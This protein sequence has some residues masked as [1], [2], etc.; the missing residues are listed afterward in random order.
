VTLAPSVVT[1]NFGTM[2][3]APFPSSGL[4]VNNLDVSAFQAG[5]D[6][7]TANNGT[8]QFYTNSAS[9]TPAFSGGYNVGITA[10]NVSFNPMTSAYYQFTITPDPG[11]EVTLTDLS[12]GT[13]STSTGP[14]DLGI[15]TSAD[16]FS[17]DI[18]T[19]TVSTTGT[20]QLREPSFTAIT[21]S[22]PLTVRIYGS[23]PEGSG[24]VSTS[25]AANWRLDDV[26]FEA[27]VQ[28]QAQCAGTPEAGSI[29]ALNDDFCGSGIT[30]ITATGYTDPGSNP[31]VSL[32]W[33]SSTNN[34]DFAPIDGATGATVVT[35]VLSQTTYYYLQVSCS[36]SGLSDVTNTVTIAINEIPATPSISGNNTV[37]TGNTTTLTSSA[38]PAGG[39][40]A[41]YNNGNP[42]GE[43]TQS[44]N[45]GAGVYTVMITSAEGCASDIS[46]SFEVTE[47]GSPAAPFVQG[48]SNVC[49]YVGTGDPVEFTVFPDPT[50]TSY[51]WTVPAY[52]T[53]VG[54][55]G[56]GTLTV[57]FQN[58]FI[59]A[60]GKQIRVTGTSACGTTP[61]TIKYLHAQIPT[62][63][64][65]ITGP[66]N[67]C[68][69]IGTAT[70]ATYSVPLVESAT[71]YDWTL[72]A[73]V[74]LVNDNGNSIDVSFTN[75]FVN[76][77]ISVRASNTCGVSNARSIA[78]KR[79]APPL[80][81]L[82]SGPTNVCLYMPTA[83]NPA[84]VEAVYSVALAANVTTYNWTVPT[85]AT[86]TDQTTTA[87]H[88][89][90]TVSYSGSFAGGSISVSATN[91][92]GTSAARTLALSQ[93]NPSTPSPIDVVNTQSC[94]NRVV[95]YSLSGMPANTTDVVWTVPVGGTI[96]SGQG[97]AS[98]QVE[99]AATPIEGTVSVTGSNGCAT[100]GTRSIAVK[101]AGCPPAP[102]Q[103][104]KP[105]VTTPAISGVE[106]EVLD[107]SIFPNPSVTDFRLKVK[108]SAKGNIQVRIFDANGVAHT[109]MIVTPGETISFG[110]HLKAGTYFVEVMQGGERKVSKIV[111]L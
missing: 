81:A 8:L 57:T 28:A 101:L 16:G 37:C 48:P 14:T 97:T 38:A 34:V 25:G 94:P 98:I 99:Y 4:P 18:A 107:A 55:Q 30:D 86:I 77:N 10:N 110:S 90:I 87:T 53:I 27:L 44:I 3:A 69:L 58:G 33:F 103:D 70:T 9:T 79:I 17:N 50:V 19:L 91:N 100:S 65:A 61:M 104:K 41:W 59:A 80:L 15:R 68:D 75:A 40:Y 102:K 51:T 22:S 45:V 20:W 76:S 6:K 13:R 106:V 54:G 109:K 11:Y 73:G 64:S 85:G 66:T 72:P 1:W 105:M 89:V 39:S 108:S 96:L 23:V 47:L 74:V 52:T 83:S 93:L 5:N 95:T 46:A 49:N 32:Q 71:D 84:G 92:C 60:P 62:T 24:S 82:I 12:F 56:T 67:V 7:N 31:G 21:T 63:P 2:A 111:K 26:T 78:V 88:S 42:M 43:T 29:S 36:G 35:G